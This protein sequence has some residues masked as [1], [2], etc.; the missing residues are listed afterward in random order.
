M[1]IDDL[2]NYEGNIFGHNVQFSPKQMIVLA[3]D[4]APA[5]SLWSLVQVL[6]LPSGCCCSHSSARM[7]TLTLDLLTTMMVTTMMMKMMMMMI[8]LT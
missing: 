6:G 5:Q 8:I 1:I 4:E 3:G 2:I 7:C